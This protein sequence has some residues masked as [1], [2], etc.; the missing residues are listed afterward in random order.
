MSTPL[1]KKQKNVLDFICT[2]LEDKGYAPSYREIAQEFSLSSVATVHQH[3]QTLQEKGYLA[4]DGKRSLELTSL[5]RPAPSASI[6]DIP[7]VGLIT[8]GQPIEALLE[9][10]QLSVPQSMVG[11]GRYYSLRVKGD[12]MIEDGILDGD[13]VVV[14]EKDQADNGDIVVALLENQF[15]TLK[16]YYK[17]KDHIRL[18]PANSSMEPFRVKNVKIQGKV[19]GLLRRYR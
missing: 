16:R 8:A 14:E 7:L 18:Q 4:S 11:R 2:F 3:V 15:A 12:S 10:E 9:H 6:V 1:T 5:A 13:Y 19:V 17:E